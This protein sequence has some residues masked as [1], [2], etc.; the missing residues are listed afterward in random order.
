MRAKDVFGDLDMKKSQLKDTA[1][2]GVEVRD[3][4]TYYEDIRS[5]KIPEMKK[6]SFE[7]RVAKACELYKARHA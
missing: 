4:E 5:V 7:P 1:Y 6:A 2:A 3:T